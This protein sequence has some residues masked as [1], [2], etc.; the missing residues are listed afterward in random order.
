MARELRF[1]DEETKAQRGEVTCSW[2]LGG[3]TAEL[4]PDPGGF[5]LSPL[6]HLSPQGVFYPRQKRPATPQGSQGRRS[7]PPLLG[8]LLPLSLLLSGSLSSFL[9]HFPST[10]S[11][12]CQALGPQGPLSQLPAA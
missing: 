7:L 4:A 6:P 2:P 8:A 10:F 9:C 11:T 3:K 12:T 5:T 1:T